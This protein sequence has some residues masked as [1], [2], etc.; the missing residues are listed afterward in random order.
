MGS[1][2]AWKTCIFKVLWP[3]AT[4]LLIASPCPSRAALTPSEATCRQRVGS[5]GRGLLRDLQKAITKCRDQ[6]SKGALPAMTDCSVEPGTASRIAK[7]E[8]QVGA[9]IAA[10]CADPWWRSSCSAARATAARRPPISRAVSST[11]T[12]S[13]RS[14]WLTS[15]YGTTGSLPDAQQKCQAAVS[16]QG[17][18]FVVQAAQA[19]HALQGHGRSRHARTDHRLWRRGRHRGQSRRR[20]AATKIAAKCPDATV[21]DH[22]LR[23]ALHRRHHRRRARRLHP[24]PAHRPRRHVDRGRVRLG[25]RA[26]PPR[27]RSRSPIP[28]TECVKGPLSRCRAGDYLLAND[29]IRVVVQDLQRNLFGIGQFGGQIIDADLRAHRPRSR[30]RQLRGVG[31]LD[32]H[33]EHRPLHVAARSSTTAATAGRGASAPPASTT[34]STSST[35]ARSSPASASPSRPRP[36]T[37]IC[38][39]RSMTD[40]ILEPGAQLGARRDDGAEHS[41]PRRSASSSAST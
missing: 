41:A 38:R 21:A 25:S 35:R 3:V 8:G 24:R 16:K 36:T 27:W 10:A 19:D 2:S 4:V 15:V 31:D 26:A 9:K 12:R 28:S 6:V 7:V 22:R 14:R 29:R 13:R 39:S 40:Y 5:V 34:C 23:Q 11:R 33:R 30:A 1:R 20:Q 18:K 17:K 32:Q 37:S